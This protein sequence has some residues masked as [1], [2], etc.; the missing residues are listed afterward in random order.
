M[1][2]L[3]IKGKDWHDSYFRK[4]MQFPIVRNQFLLWQ[5]PQEL[6]KYINFDSITMLDTTYI[7]KN[8]K[9]TFSDV[10]FDCQYE[11]K[12]I[13]AKIIILIEHQSTPEKFL[14]VRVHHYMHNVLNKLLLEQS[15]KKANK[16]LPAIYPMIYYNGKTKTYPYSTKLQDCLSGP[17]QAKKYFCNEDIKVVNVNELTQQEIEQHQLAGIMTHAMKRTKQDQTPQNYQAVLG[18]L[19]DIL[20][21]EQIPAGFT[22]ST[23]EYM[24]NVKAINNLDELIEQNLDLTENIRGEA[25]TIAEALRAEGEERGKQIGKQEYQTKVAITMLKDGMPNDQIA[26]F[27]ELDLSFIQQLKQQH[28]IKH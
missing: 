9:K 25:M 7:D 24:M 19:S 18:Q 11:N 15:G 21:P 16:P 28:D 3:L 22:E 8:L 12:T 14:P 1:K 23:I 5:V 10:V 6:T 20:D 2:T 13:T 27:T 17:G 4:M 26:K